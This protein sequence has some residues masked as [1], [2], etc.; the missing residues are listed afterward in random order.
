MTTPQ[1]PFHQ[2]SFSMS[3]LIF[4]AILNLV[5]KKTTAAGHE[6]L[7]SHLSFN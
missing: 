7:L 3:V 6:N 5:E 2:T 4:P 1:I